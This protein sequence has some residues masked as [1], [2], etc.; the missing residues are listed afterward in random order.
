MALVLSQ[1]LVNT[2]VKSN[3]SN[4]TEKN[5]ITRIISH[6]IKQ[7]VMA[8]VLCQILVNTTTV[9]SNFS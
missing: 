1:I 5:T 2:T 9:K 8:L 4:K 7:Y 6:I 3:F